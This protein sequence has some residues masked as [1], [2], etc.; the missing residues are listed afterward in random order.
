VAEPLENTVDSLSSSVFFADDRLRLALDRAGK[1][2]AS[3]IKTLNVGR[4]SEQGIV[5]EFVAK[6]LVAMSAQPEAFDAACSYNIKH[7]GERFRR[8]IQQ[9]LNYDKVL[10]SELLSACYRFITEFEI[11]S[12]SV[13]RDS[14][15]AAW[16]RLLLVDLSTFPESSFEIKYAQY[17]MPIYLM[18]EYIS[19]PHM[20]TLSELPAAIVA[21]QL[22][23]ETHERDLTDR[24][25][26]ANVLAKNLEGYASQL[27]FLGLAKGFQQ[28]R[29]VKERER[30]WSLRFTR[31]L[32]VVLIA[33]PIAKIQNWLPTSDVTANQIAGGVAI[34]A[35]ELMLIYFFRI[36][37]QNFKSVK[38]QLLQLDL[39]V[40]LCQFIEGYTKFA[41]EAKKDDDKEILTRFEQVVFSSIVTD[42][43]GIPSTF[44]GIEQISGLIER[45]KK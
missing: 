42:E 3:D 38:A 7:I 22:T 2:I 31:G 20:Q 32:G 18:R 35:L 43:T 15:S 16:H 34:L 45:L 24:E 29:D 37:L 1:L 23:T 26:R 10:M 25:N 13:L 33:L 39:R 5:M 17:H 6:A 40:T 21:S 28:L 41:K 30:E 11:K 44:D 4:D 19:H 8:D 9:Y 14:L 36:T 27:N 12:K